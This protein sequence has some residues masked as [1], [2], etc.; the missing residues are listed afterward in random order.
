MLPKLWK[1][2]ASRDGVGESWWI[3]CAPRQWSSPR[4]VLIPV[5]GAVDSTAIRD[6]PS[7]SAA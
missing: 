4:R 2:L 5:V 6:S 1:T 7:I 3:G